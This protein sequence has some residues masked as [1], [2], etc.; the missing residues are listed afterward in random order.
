[1]KNKLALSLLVA[2]TGV[3]EGYTVKLFLA[4]DAVYALNCEAEGEIVGEGTG[5][6]KA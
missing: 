2:V 3:K 5:D 1:M 4:A 6:V